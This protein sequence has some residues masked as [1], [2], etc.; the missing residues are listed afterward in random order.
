MHAYTPEPLD[1]GLLHAKLQS[2]C[3]M[4]DGYSF[5]SSVLHCVYFYKDPW[6]VK[7]HLGYV[8]LSEIAS[9]VSTFL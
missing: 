2:F 8:R 5:L 4:L 6:E 9:K 3:G 7:Y 1:F